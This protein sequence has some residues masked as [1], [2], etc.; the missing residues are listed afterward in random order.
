[1]RGL[2]A[3]IPSN[4]EP[5]AAPRLL[6]CMTT[7]LLPIISRRRSVCSPIFEMAPS[8][9]LPPVDICRGV[10]PSHAAKSRPRL[11]FS[12]GG[13]NAAIAVAVTGP[14]GSVGYAGG[15]GPTAH[16]RTAL[17]VARCDES[18]RSLTLSGTLPVLKSFS[19]P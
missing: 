14:M 18:W 15:A 4:H 6:A 8:F 3:S 13:A 9:C 2:R 11:K 5:L 7:A 16:P 19:L 10:R 12:A 17:L 1:M